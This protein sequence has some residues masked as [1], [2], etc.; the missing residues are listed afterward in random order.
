ME[1]Q[2]QPCIDE[3]E[4]I[5][6]QGIRKGAITARQIVINGREFDVEKTIY[7]LSVFLRDIESEILLIAD[8]KN[9]GNA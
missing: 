3:K 6:L 9:V 7:A 4:V 1:D 5:F 2:C 8:D